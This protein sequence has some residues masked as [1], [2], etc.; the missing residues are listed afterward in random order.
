MFLKPEEIYTKFNEENIQ[1]V[2][3][4]KLLFTLLQQV[5]RYREV[6]SNQEEVVN[7]FAIHDYISNSEMLMV[8]LLILLAEPSGKNEVILETSIAEFLTLR[9][10]V[11]CNYLLPH[12]KGKMRLSI[13]KAYKKFYDEVE[14]IFGTLDSNEVN[15]YWNY[16]KNFKFEGSVL[17]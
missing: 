10:F 9:D 12:L 2:I 15:T 14:D 13:L 11:F 5:D 6:L 17:Q 3:S 8:K 4:K 16:L 1:I 7:N